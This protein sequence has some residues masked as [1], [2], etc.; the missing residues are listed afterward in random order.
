MAFHW[1]T[2]R[3]ENVRSYVF[4]SFVVVID[5]PDPPSPRPPS[6]RPLLGSGKLHVKTVLFI[7][8]SYVLREYASALYRRC[9]SFIYKRCFILQF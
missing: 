4:Y 7:W 9:N 3:A 5:L 6:D 1:C 8:A 2:E